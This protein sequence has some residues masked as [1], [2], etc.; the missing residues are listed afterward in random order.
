M[1][2]EKQAASIIW[3]AH[4]GKMQLTIAVHGGGV[5]TYQMDAAT[6][7]RQLGRLHDMLADMSKGG[8]AQ[9]AK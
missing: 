7:H 5:I 9:Q 8:R 4:D 3:T 6:F 2:P 1:T